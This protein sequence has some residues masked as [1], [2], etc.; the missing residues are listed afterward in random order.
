VAVSRADIHGDAC[1]GF[2]RFLSL[3]V[4]FVRF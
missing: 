4:G 2:T 1:G 3:K